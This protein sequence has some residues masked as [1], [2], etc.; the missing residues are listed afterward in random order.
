MRRGWGV[1]LTQIDRI[2]TGVA[3]LRSGN[4]RG[5]ERDYPQDQ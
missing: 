2:E 1:I 4:L 5:L 3:V